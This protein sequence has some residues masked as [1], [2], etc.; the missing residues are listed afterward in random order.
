MNVDIRENFGKIW[1]AHVGS[2]TSFLLACRRAFDG[3]MDLFLV[4]AVIGDRTFSEKNAVRDVKFDEWQACD[5]N[6]AIPENINI[7]SISDY[8]GIARETVRRKVCMLIDRGWVNRDEK[9]SLS[10]TLKC[11]SDLEATTIDA[12]KYI[13][14][15]FKLLSSFDAEPA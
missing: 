2:L 13:E 12:I 11:R 15:M 8:S 5:D 1:P 10:A 6:Y 3:D 14:S 4:L 9:G 7:Q